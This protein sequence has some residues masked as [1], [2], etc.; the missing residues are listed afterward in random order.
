[1]SNIKETVSNKLN[2]RF[3]SIEEGQQ[4]IQRNT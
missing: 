4:L 2:I 3:A 1:M